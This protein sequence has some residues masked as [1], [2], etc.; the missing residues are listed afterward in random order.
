MIS[1][2]SY[3]SRDSQGEAAYE[4][5]YRRIIDL[6][7]QGIALHAVEGDKTDYDRFREDVDQC[8]Q[9][10]A[11]EESMAELLVIVGRA[12]R[13]MEDYNHRTSIFVRRQNTELQHMVSM[14]TE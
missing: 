2:K 10:V 4:A 9:N 11:V 8:A 6:F 12:L 5:A 14:L 13:A 3:L 1:L 7:L